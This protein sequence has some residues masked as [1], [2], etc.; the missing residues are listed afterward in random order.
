MEVKKIFIDKLY[1]N[2]LPSEMCSVAIPFAKG[3]LTTDQLQGLVLVDDLTSSQRL[4]SQIKVTSTW[5]D[6]SIRFLFVRFLADIPGN[7]KKSLR[8]EL[9]DA[10]QSGD[11]NELFAAPNETLKVTEEPGMI[12]VDTGSLYFEVRDNSKSLFGKVC[13]KEKVYE[14]GQFVGPVLTNKGKDCDLHIDKWEIVENGPVCV[15]IEGKGHYN[16]NC[17]CD[18]RLTAIRGKSFVDVSFR[19]FNDSDI[20]LI[21]DSWKMFVKTDLGS[22]VN[23]E[24]PLAGAGKTDSTGCGDMN[25]TEADED[26][27]FFNTTGTG[28]LSEIEQDIKSRG[29]GAV[30]SISGISNYKTRFTISG[31]GEMVSNQIN[32]QML[33]GEANEHFAEVLY[34]TLFADSTDSKGGVCA[35]VF[36]AHQNFP[37]AVKASAD[38]VCVFLIPE[39]DEKVRFSQGM[40]REQRILLHFHDGSESIE[41]IDDR[42]LVYQMPVLPYVLPEE[43]DKAK[44]FPNVITRADKA[45]GDVELA[46][47]GRADNHGRAY[48]M[49]N[50]GDFPDSNYTA[51]GRGGGGLV[52]TNNEY[53]YP[54]AMFMMY[55]RSGVRRFHDYAV[56]AARHWMDVDVCHY[57]SDELHEGGQWEHTKGHN[58]GGDEGGVMVCSHEW[59]EGL[60]DLWHFT[61]DERAFETAIGIGQNVLRLLDTPMYQKTGEASARE[62]GWALRSL[63]ALYIETHD[64]RWLVKCRTIVGQFE[65]WNEKYGA[66]LAPYTDNTVIRVGFMISV[67]IGSLMRYYREFPDETLKNLI[68]SAVD[69]LTENSMNPYGL[70]Y[71][72]ELPSLA[73]NGG[74]ALLLEAMAIGYELTGDKKYLQCGVKTFWNNIKDMPSNG[75]GKR[76]AEDAV[77]VGSAP[78]K[79]FGQSF[80]PLMQFYNSMIDAGMMN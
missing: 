49:M 19:L 45:D 66:W 56:V 32:G 39:G 16:D 78:T 6:G 1:K 23:M 15:V 12:K 70:F 41:K 50:W 68:M 46:M 7:G 63:T 2:D 74:N 51:Q 43:F 28:M 9:A 75:G 26:S 22:T 8:L 33:V 4:F 10:A 11:G 54:H 69:D 21:P 65:E 52:W 47:I 44:V 20:A 59:V 60:L 57:S 61:G 3:E 71:Y 29:K 67:A 37:K 34:G 17:R 73:R 40:A 76:I 14:S 55:A 79:N 13:I 27:L 53:D 5:E 80:V 35:T 38:G 30:R 72:K 31:K 18:V 58:A 25:K 77:L 24:L 36:Q 48:G 42:S 64:S 62:T